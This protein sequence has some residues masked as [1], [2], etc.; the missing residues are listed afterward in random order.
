M[1][2]GFQNGWSHGLS[3]FTDLSDKVQKLRTGLEAGLQDSGLLGPGEAPPKDTTATEGIPSV[4]VASI[5]EDLYY[6][7]LRFEASNALNGTACH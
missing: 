3:Q 7:W 4:K 6:S 1:F 5:F 2:G